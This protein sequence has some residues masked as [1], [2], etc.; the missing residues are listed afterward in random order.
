MCN[1][2]CI[3]ELADDVMYL[4]CAGYL[5]FISSI[6]YSFPW[7][8]QTFGSLCISYLYCIRVQ[9]ISIVLRVCFSDW[10]CHHA[11][12]STMYFCEMELFSAEQP[13]RRQNQ[14][15]PLIQYSVPNY[16]STSAYLHY[17]VLKKTLPPPFLKAVY[18]AYRVPIVKHRLHQI[19]LRTPAPL[20]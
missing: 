4:S 9:G 20:V 5:R 17:D 15:F 14:I 13:L 1:I 2:L 19:I 18:S 16:G 11:R 7:S 10:D 6:F 8:L 3:S 12:T